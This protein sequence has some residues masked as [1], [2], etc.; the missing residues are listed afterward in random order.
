MEKFELGKCYKHG[1]G[2]EMYICGIADTMLY[3]TG[4]VAETNRGYDLKP[5]AMNDADACANWV[6]IKK[7]DFFKNNFSKD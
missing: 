1:A 6:E 7:E 5:I 4:F 3:G 2:E